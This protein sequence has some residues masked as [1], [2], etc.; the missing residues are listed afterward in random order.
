MQYAEHSQL[1]CRENKFR[2]I[3][4]TNSS[5]LPLLVLGVTESS[6][7]L[8]LEHFESYIVFKHPD[9]VGF[10]VANT[11][12]LENFPQVLPTCVTRAISCVGAVERLATHLTCLCGYTFIYNYVFL[13]HNPYINL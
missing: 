4:Y 13:R 10:E 8:F 3:F 9:I 2:T 6:C 12:E 7:M 5:F 1:G 11:L